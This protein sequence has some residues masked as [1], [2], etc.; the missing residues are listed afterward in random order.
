MI[1]IV[2][3]TLNEEEYL[4]QLLESIEK[5]TYDD[6]EVIVADAGSED[7]T[8]EIA[9]E[10]GCKVVEGGLPAEGRNKGAEAARG[11]LLVFV[12][13]DFLLPSDYLEKS[14][15]EFKQ[16]DLG[17]ADT[18]YKFYDASWFVNFIFHLL[19]NWP[20]KL[21]QR[22]T[23][24]SLTAIFVRKEVFEEVSGF[25]ESVEFA[26]DSL[27]IEETAEIS[28]FRF[29]NSVKTLISARRFKQEGYAKVLLKYLFSNIYM[30]LTGRPVKS[31]TF[32]YKFDEYEKNQKKE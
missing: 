28:K 3:I 14:I 20:A 16:R 7:R 29:L 22:F 11:E 18:L 5:Q 9:R 10:H 19:V 24:T 32:D 26:E 4:P 23:P 2:I 17:V 8:R 15:Q 12:D 1:S 6:Y 30:W 13:A 31:D 21:L 27:F 25:D